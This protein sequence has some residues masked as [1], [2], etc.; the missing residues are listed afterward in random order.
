MGLGVSCSLTPTENCG[1]KRKTR[2]GKAAFPANEAM[3]CKGAACSRQSS[4]NAWSC[5][6][7]KR[8]DFS[9]G[10]RGDRKAINTLKGM[11]LPRNE[12]LRRRGEVGGAG[13][14]LQHHSTPGGSRVLG[15]A[16]SRG[17]DPGPSEQSLCGAG[18]G[19]CQ[20]PEL[21]CPHPTHTALL[22]RERAGRA[23]RSCAGSRTP[24]WAA[25]GAGRAGRGCLSQ[26]NFPFIV[27][28]FSR[29]S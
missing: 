25:G 19:S 23:A 1:V 17:K 8:G 16:L 5:G 11:W 3:H 21:S 28:H 27:S 2:Q 9:P 26:R 14:R 24:A 13:M 15:R 10:Q 18:G 22:A 20:A 4:S 6:S 29:G 7:L 12:N